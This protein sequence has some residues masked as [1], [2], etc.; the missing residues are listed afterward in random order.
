MRIL[1]LT[2]AFNSLSQR[3][4][5]ELVE[6]GHTLAV[7]LDISDAVTEDAAERFR[8]DLIIA[9]YLKRAIPEAVW[10]RFV[11]LIVHPGPPGDRGPASL[12][13]AILEKRTSWGV[14]VLQAEAE[15]DAGPVWAGRAFPLNHGRK[16][17]LYR[18]ALSD[19]A[20]AA[21]LE[22]ADRFAAGG[23]VPAYPPA[24]A[25]HQSPPL[26]AAERRVDWQ[27]DTTAVVRRKIDS[28]D[29]APGAV[30]EWAGRPWRLFDVG[31]EDVLC[32]PP[33]AWLARCHGALCRATADGAVW[34]GQIK[35]APDGFKLPAATVLGGAARRLP[36]VQSDPSA[37]HLFSDSER[38]TRR[39]IEYEEYGPIGIVRFDF[40]NGAMSTRRCRRLLAAWRAVCRRPT[41]VLILAGGADFWSNGL[42]LNLIEA[43][44]SPADE[45]WRNIQAMDDLAQAIITTTDRY[46][47][48]ALGGNAAAGGAFLA[49]A[50]DEVWCRAGVILNPHYK[51]MGNLY[52]SEYWTYLLPR[53]IGQDAAAAVMTHRLPLGAVAA[54]R[55]GLIDRIGPL[56]REAFDDWV[57][58][59]ARALAGGRGFAYLLAEKRRRR[60]ADEAQKPLAAYRAEELA[61]MR[62]NFYGFDPSYHVARHRFVHR[63]PHAWTPLHLAPHRRLGWQTPSGARRQTG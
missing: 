27:A 40:Y 22:A 12:D 10:R 34:I 35:A 5:A 62:L 26:A 60:A 56:D 1:L 54:A 53:R 49:L 52:G 41:Q 42:D 38:R 57:S 58:A 30:D 9:P 33:G 32:G 14:T 29:G 3:L 25:I 43:A 16:S 31:V 48:A 51:N 4:Y 45:S 28:A 61:R 21:V 39:E 2:H 23:Y 6:H 13:R 18:F 37:A 46:T 59:E 36:E 7:E 47:I 44:P 8:P 17:H 50:A 20:V 55:L 19:A 24:A 63:A 15:L 11:C